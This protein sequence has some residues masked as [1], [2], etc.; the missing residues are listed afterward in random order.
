MEVTFSKVKGSNFVDLATKGQ[1]DIPAPGK[2]NQV[3][4]NKISRAT[5]FCQVRRFL[6]DAPLTIVPQSNAAVL[7]GKEVFGTTLLYSS[8]A[9]V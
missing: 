8:Y 9:A 5:Q 6:A 7:P 1:G 4:L 2:Y 3:P